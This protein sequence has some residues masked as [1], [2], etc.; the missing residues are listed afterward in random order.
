MKRVTALILSIL[1]LI[2]TGCE[3]PHACV[4]TCES[5]GLCRNA[6]CTESAC[7]D[8]CGGHHSCTRICEI[9]NLCE[10]TVCT[11]AVCLEKCPGHHSC[12]APCPDCGLCG[13]TECTESLCTEKCPGHP[14]APYAFPTGDYI[15]TE[16][17]SVDTG[18]FVY[19]IGEN[20]YVRGDLQQISDVIVPLMEEV[21]GLDFNGA[22]YSTG[23]WNDGRIHITLS[24]DELYVG[25][26]WYT[27]SPHSEVG[28]AY[29]SAYSHVSCSPGDLYLGNSAIIHEASHV[30]MFRQSS[31]SHCQLL[32]EGISTYTT[33]L[34]EKALEESHGAI[35]YCVSS[36]LESV[37]D[38]FI[39]DYDALYAQPLEYWFENSFEYS[40]NGNYAIGFRFMAYL[41]DVYGNY[42]GWVTKYEELYC[43]NTS[44]TNTN[45]SPV[46]TQI[47]VL[48]A[49]Y[50]DDVLDNF[51][52]W[53]K[54]HQQE[55]EPDY[56]AFRDLSGAEGINL[57]PEFDA[58][59]CRAAIDNFRYNDLYIHI[60]TVRTYVEDY[61]QMDASELTLLL[62]SET[63]V[64]L[65]QA[66]GSYI[67]ETGT[68]FPLT[69]ILCIQLVGEGT[70]SRLEV[71][72]PFTDGE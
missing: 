47:E 19:D 40:G 43:F 42:T 35:S 59:G 64:R 20:I 53:L 68:E 31:W 22:G 27:G 11:E 16:P 7:A 66:D 71:R 14:S 67:T 55:F 39:E 58:I 13:N 36:P 62:S 25:A 15:T 51:Y 50:G 41:Q 56:S 63:T 18:T 3:D 29:A 57:Y 45:A 38:M 26:D 32:N 70:L 1:L 9:C 33:Y 2:I 37:N 69:D 65:Y 12:S 44:S 6:D 8:K 61:K 34:V 5:C 48:K 46:S 23:R 21:S 17:V 54:E 28:A 24:R 10:N 49:T 4:S 30:L 52:P 60:D 72:G